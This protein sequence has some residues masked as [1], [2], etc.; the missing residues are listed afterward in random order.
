[1]N[2]SNIE[3]LFYPKPFQAN[4]IPHILKELYIDQ[5][6]REYFIGR[7]NL[8]VLDLGA[9]IGL[10]SMYAAP[11]SK[12]IVAVEPDTDNFACL[13]LNK[14]S[15]G[16]TEKLDVMKVAMGGH[17]G[18]LKLYHTP[19]K[20]AHTL[21]GSGDDFEEVDVITLPALLK[22]QKIKHVDLMKI[23]IEG[24]E[25]DVLCGEE[26]AKVA[27]RVNHIFGEMHDWAGR[28][29]GQMM[30]SLKNLGFEYRLVNKTEASVFEAW[31]SK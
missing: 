23:D 10:F 30:W 19:N 20:T 17:E 24:A 8:T 25:F 5:V 4:F 9:N 6:Y 15:M 13:M 26:F 18:K 29:Y 21:L 16:M 22:E 31:R 28:N 11:Y 7:K 14:D 2:T 27:S 12:R 1:M 3:S